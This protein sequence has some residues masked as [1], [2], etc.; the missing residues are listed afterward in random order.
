MG[1]R[2]FKRFVYFFAERLNFSAARMKKS[3]TRDFSRDNPRSNHNSWPGGSSIRWRDESF[4]QEDLI[5]YVANNALTIRHW[6]HWIVSHYR[7]V[8]H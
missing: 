8:Y 1:R 6:H 4:G 5:F 7:V 2:G 3:Q